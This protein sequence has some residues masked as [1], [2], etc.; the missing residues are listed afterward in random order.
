MSW[1]PTAS[2]STA[3]SPSWTKYYLHYAGHRDTLDLKALYESYPD[4]SQLEQAQ[5]LGEAAERRQGVS[6][7]W[8]FASENYLAELTREHAEKRGAGG[9][10]RG[11]G[12]RRDDRL[13][14]DPADGRERGGPRR[15]KRLEGKR[16]RLTEEHINPI[17]I[18]G[19]ATLNEAVP[20]LK[21][22]RRTPTCTGASASGSTSSPTS[23]APSS[24][25][26]R[27]STRRRPT[28]CSA[29]RPESG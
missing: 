16:S 15:E 4:L 17:H 23:A 13:P 10:A 12:G 3:S 22:R 7:L 29:P 1:T 21:E 14:D 27:R 8:R 26:P 18:D 2:A 6:E 24:T 9:A 11:H 25:R 20:R 5:A 28:S 19:I